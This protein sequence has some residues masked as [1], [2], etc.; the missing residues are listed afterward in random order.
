MTNFLLSIKNL[1]IQ[2]KNKILRT[3]ECSYNYSVI[4]DIVFETNLD[5]IEEYRKKKD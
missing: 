4:D 5:L 3:G 1:L 2:L